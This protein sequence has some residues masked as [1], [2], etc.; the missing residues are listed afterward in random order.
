MYHSNTTGPTKVTVRDVLLQHL[1]DAAINPDPTATTSQKGWTSYFHSIIGAENYE[2]VPATWQGV[3]DMF[4]AEDSVDVER[5]NTEVYPINEIPQQLRTE[6]DS[7]RSADIDLIQPVA[8]AFTIL[9]KG[10]VR[11]LAE[12]TKTTDQTTTK[13]AITTRVDCIFE[14]QLPG[15]TKTVAAVGEYKKVGVLTQHWGP[16]GPYTEPGYILKLGSEAR[17]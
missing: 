10:L 1:P 14:H 12:V 3:N 2:R 17:G 8:L 6:G 4:G 13:P 7:V 15:R 9:D 16:S 11:I 5:L